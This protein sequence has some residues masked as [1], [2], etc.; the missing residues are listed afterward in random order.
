MRVERGTADEENEELPS[1]E[2]S[3]KKLA[4]QISN[5]VLQKK[6]ARQEMEEQVD[7]Q[8]RDR[9]MIAN[10]ARGRSYTQKNHIKPYGLILQLIL[11]RLRMG[12]LTLNRL[13]MGTRTLESP[14]QS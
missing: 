9:E 1:P 4:R 11:N 3:H 14:L 5:Y 7:S 13:R 6:R 12:T 8:D 2:P 10:R